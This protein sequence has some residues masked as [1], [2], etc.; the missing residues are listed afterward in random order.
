MT[1]N[2]SGT[3]IYK[4]AQNIK[5]RLEGIFI[6]LDKYI[7]EH[8]EIDLS[9]PQDD[10]LALFPPTSPLANLEPPLS[11]L[12]LIANDQPV[13]NELDLILSAPPLESLFT[14]EFPE[15]KPQPLPAPAP[16]KTKKS[17]SKSKKQRD[18]DSSP[19]FRAPRTL[20]PVS[21]EGGAVAGPSTL[22]EVVAEER[23]EETL[24]EIA[25]TGDAPKSSKKPKRAPVVL[26]GHEPPHLVEN[27]DNH[28]SFTMF[29]AG[30]VLPDGHKRARTTR[31]PVPP[32]K[33]RQRVGKSYLPHQPEYHS[34]LLLTINRRTS[35]ITPVDCQYFYCG[36]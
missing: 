35:E 24:A 27:I 23:A 12:E 4:T 22:P 7:Q 3:P 30:W 26:P 17:K 14:Y 29:N 2:K 10:L 32:P 15:F 25:S 33:K 18:L 6:D 9:P 11:L 5:N 20:P 19:G 1:Y 28:D 21:V 36:E 16:P 13:V 34:I 31:G 8:T